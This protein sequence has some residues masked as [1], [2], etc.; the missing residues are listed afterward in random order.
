MY[1]SVL[2]ARSRSLESRD[3]KQLTGDAGLTRCMLAA[4]FHKYI[5]E[6]FR[7]AQE[8]DFDAYSNDIMIAPDVLAE[9][10]SKS[11]ARG[12]R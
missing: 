11:E 1:A 9:R 2:S 8:S 6:R 10:L 12:S 4:A 7:R 5:S 3:S